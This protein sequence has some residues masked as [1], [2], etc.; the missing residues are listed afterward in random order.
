MFFFRPGDRV[1]DESSRTD[2][3]YCCP[4]CGSPVTIEPIDSAGDSPC[5]ECG[6]LIWFVRR[7]IDETV[8]LT[9]LPGLMMSSESLDRVSEVKAAIG[10]AP[11]GILDLAHIHFLSSIFLGLLVA[12]HRWLNADARALR[13]CAVQP[14]NREVFRITKLDGMLTLCDDEQI[15]LESF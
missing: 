1:M 2:M 10:E 9:F 6:H 7:N 3:A 15:A 5:S 12:M 8:I 11:R 13:I 14:D 4:A